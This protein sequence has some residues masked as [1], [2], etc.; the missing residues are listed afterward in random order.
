LWR[1]VRQVVQT[2]LANFQVDIELFITVSR[3]SENLIRPFLPRTSKFENIGNP[4]AI[5]KE[6]PVD[7]GNNST[8]TFIGRLSPEKGAVLFA[9]AARMAKVNSVFVGSGDE[10]ERIRAMNSTSTFMGWQDRKGVI[11]AIR[12]SRAVVFPSLLHEAQPLIVMEAAA[13]GVPVVASDEC[14][15]RD[16]IID[17]ETGLL[18]RARDPDDLSKKL[19]LLNRDPDLARRLAAN[20]YEHYWNAPSTLEVHVGKLINCYEKILS[21]VV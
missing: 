9:E 11:K 10:E 17:G 15:A 12:A 16:A 3:Y 8:F 21:P 1:V 14:A 2:K 4:I 13:L 19:E 20:A 5:A 6:S 18:F 7:V